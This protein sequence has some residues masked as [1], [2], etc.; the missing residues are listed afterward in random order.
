MAKRSDNGVIIFNGWIESIRSISDRVARAELAE[1][2]IN[3]AYDGTEYQGKKEI[4]R[5]MMKTISASIDFK[6][7]QSEQNAENGKRGGN[8]ALQGTRADSS[9]N[10]SDN[11]A[12]NRPLNRSD[13]PIIEIDKRNELQELDI[14]KEDIDK[15]E[16]SSSPKFVFKKALI[17]KGCSNQIASDY[18]AIRNRRKAPSTKTAFEGIEKEAEK[19][20]AAQP[21]ATFEDVVRI[22]IEHNWLG[23]E[24]TWVLKDQG[25]QPKSE[26][27]DDLDA[28][29]KQWRQQLEEMRAA[30]GREPGQF[31]D[32]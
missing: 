8:P 6:K 32:L 25:M 9:D 19:Y 12:D 10:R 13:K 14:L 11:Q 28:M 16:P 1:A 21:G 7:R 20:I 4:V 5:V 27:Q 23:F 22:M 2:I 26:A 15:A 17:D 24:A 18:M 3:Y 30:D 31:K 29:A